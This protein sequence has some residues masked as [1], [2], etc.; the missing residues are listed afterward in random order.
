MAQW[1][2]RICYKLLS[3]FTALHLS[4][5]INIPHPSH[6][7]CCATGANKK[8]QKNEFKPVQ[9][10]AAQNKRRY[11]RLQDVLAGSR[12]SDSH[13]I[14]QRKPIIKGKSMNVYQSRIAHPKCSPLLWS[15]CQ[16]PGVKRIRDPTESP[17]QFWSA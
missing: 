11:M 12:E 14:V 8:T 1:R 13:I 5:S 15:E 17:I 4:T 6:P 3:P 10:C 9:Y 7:Y 2:Y 16:V